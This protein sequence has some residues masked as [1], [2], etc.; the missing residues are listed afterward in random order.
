MPDS[1]PI[2]ILLRPE[3]VL[4]AIVDYAQQSRNLPPGEVAAKLLSA[5]DANG[6]T[7]QYRL[8]VVYHPTIA[9]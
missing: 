8:E 4:K 5:N 7:V 3:E 6:T 2:F 1:K 9:L